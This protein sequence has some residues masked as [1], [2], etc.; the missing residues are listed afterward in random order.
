MKDNI[1]GKVDIYF[2]GIKLNGVE[3]K[4]INI[5]KYKYKKID[6]EN[7][8]TYKKIYRK[9]GWICKKCKNVISLFSAKCTKC[10]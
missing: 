7:K 1:I 8:P 2:N 3:E 10:N 6:R 5:K 9:I 4:I